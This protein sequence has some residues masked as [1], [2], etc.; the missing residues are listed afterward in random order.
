LFSRP[1]LT[2]DLNVENKTSLFSKIRPKL[3]NFYAKSLHLYTTYTQNLTTAQTKL[4]DQTTVS[5]SRDIGSHYLYML[6]IT[7]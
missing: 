7:Q 2:H 4:P 6:Y 1:R 5:E 3:C